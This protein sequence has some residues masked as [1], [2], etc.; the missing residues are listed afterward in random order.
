MALR[1]YAKYDADALPGPDDAGAMVPH[2]R[3]WP[4]RY[5]RSGQIR[6]AI[7]ASLN[8]AVAPLP[9]AHRPTPIGTVET[10]VVLGRHDKG[11]WRR[12]VHDPK[13]ARSTCRSQNWADP[14][15]PW[16]EAAILAASLKASSS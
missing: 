9:I 16:R 12:C 10:A 5:G 7:R 15:E 3:R 8:L 1:G 6:T 4:Q 11:F 13:D 14:H 2:S